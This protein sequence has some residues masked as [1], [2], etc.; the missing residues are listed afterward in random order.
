MCAVELGMIVIRSL[1]N[2]VCVSRIPFAYFLG[3]VLLF[4]ENFLS[5]SIIRAAQATV[6][7]FSET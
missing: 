1:F 5:L 7:D 2:H 4:T 6:L 3:I